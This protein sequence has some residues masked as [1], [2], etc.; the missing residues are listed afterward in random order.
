MHEPLLE[1]TVVWEDLAGMMNEIY[2][3]VLTLQFPALLRTERQNGYFVVSVG[4]TLNA[5][6]YTDI[7]TSLNLVSWPEPLK[8]A[9]RTWA[10]RECVLTAINNK[11]LIQ[12]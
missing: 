9:F 8:K 5:I 7:K 1:G 3:L 10:G 11:V 6:H 2:S 4:E 12:H